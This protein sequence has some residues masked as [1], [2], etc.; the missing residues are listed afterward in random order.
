MRTPN[1]LCP[2]LN[3]FVNNYLKCE[4]CKNSKECLPYQYEIK[5]IKKEEQ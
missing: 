4:K 3:E 5:L 2:E 1:F